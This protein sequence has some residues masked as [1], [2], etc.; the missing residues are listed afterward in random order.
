MR[1]RLGRKIYDIY[2][3]DIESHN[4]EESKRKRETSMWL[5]CFINEESR[6]EDEASYFYTMGEFL[7]R[8]ESL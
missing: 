8:C 5:G 3:M 2:A 4:D 1:Q 6:K 7:D